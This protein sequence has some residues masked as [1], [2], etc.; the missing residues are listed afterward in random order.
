MELKRATD[1]IELTADEVETVDNIDHRERLL[2]P[3]F[4]PF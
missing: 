4:G 3:D 2:N 1:R